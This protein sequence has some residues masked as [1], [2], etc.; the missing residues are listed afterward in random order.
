[1]A[2]ESRWLRAVDQRRRA[3]MTYLAEASELLGQSL[4]VELTVARRAPGRGAPA[5]P[6]VRGAPAEPRARCAWP[7]SPTPTRT[8]CPSCA[9][10]LD[11]DARPGPPA[12]AA[13]PARR[14]G[15]DGAGAGALRRADRRDRACRC[16]PAGPRSARCWWVGPTG[17]P[18]TPE[19]VVLVGDI[20][21]RAALAIH[22]AQSTARTRRGVPGAAAGPAPPRAAGGAA[23]SSSPRST[24][25][26]APGS[27]V[28]G[29]FY[30]V[31]A[32][33]PAQLARLDRRRLRQ[34]RPGRRPHRPRPRRPA[35]AGA[36][37]PLAAAG[38]RAAQRRD[39]GGRRPAAVLHARRGDA[40]SRRG[41]W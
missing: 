28:G 32:L 25:P 11:P 24:C 5:G 29:D 17:A 9:R 4:D 14:A 31:L 8:S 3:W 7:R 10:S 16:A 38:R 27:D 13:R 40:S 34:G 23:V 2:V 37:R 15:R 22:N 18:H 41:R 6:L 30:D 1:M 20:A 19:D 39:D 35:G 26:R 12:G 36:R 21:R 33:D